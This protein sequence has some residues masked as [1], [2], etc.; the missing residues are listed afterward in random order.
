MIAAQHIKAG[1]NHLRKNDPVMKRIIKQ[2]GP[3]TLKLKRDRFK[4]LV[5]SIISQ[6][7][8]TS[9]AATIQQ[10]LIDAI[11]PDPLSPESL[12]SFDVDKF[13]TLGIS[14]Q[15]AT[16]IIDIVEKCHSG[17][18]QL[19]R[20]GHMDDEAAIEHLT[21]VKGVGRWTA[22]MLLIFSLGRLDVM[23]IDDLG[24]RNAVKIAYEL[25]EP[26]DRDGL[27][28]MSQPWRPYRSIASWYL[29]QSLQLK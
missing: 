5:G 17:Q 8:S 12:R 3:F 11:S 1:Q 26:T 24:L 29:W 16:Y 2:V 27:L 6:Q 22:Q 10:R 4:T 23:A 28:A 15:K 9:A 20:L 25:N 18:L 19:N 13:R 7:I 14:R 21:A